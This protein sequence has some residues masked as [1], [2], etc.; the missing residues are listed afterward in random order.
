MKKYNTKMKYDEKSNTIK[1]EVGG[2]TKVVSLNELR[3]GCKC[4]T[5]VNEISETRT[6][7]T[8]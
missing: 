5:C 4:G 7:S 6:A 2:K 3:L 1:L 8:S